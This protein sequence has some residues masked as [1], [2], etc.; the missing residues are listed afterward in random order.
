MF[1]KEEFQYSRNIS[2][3]TE[4]Q[5]VNEIVSQALVNEERVLWSRERKRIEGRATTHLCDLGRSAS[6]WWAHS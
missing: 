4:C 3:P 6:C 2:E 1:W 5:T